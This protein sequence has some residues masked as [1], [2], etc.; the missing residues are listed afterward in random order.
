MRKND[1][2]EE[3]GEAEDVRKKISLVNIDLLG[4]DQ[5]IRSIYVFLTL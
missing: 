4:G 3:E 2:R 5:K 1:L